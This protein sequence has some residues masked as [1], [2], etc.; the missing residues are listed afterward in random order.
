MRTQRIH[1]ARASLILVALI[2]IAI[3][4]MARFQLTEAMRP[5]NDIHSIVTTRA[6][7]LM[8]NREVA[9]TASSTVPSKTNTS[10]STPG[11]AAFIVSVIAAFGVG[12]IVSALITARTTSKH[13]NT[14][15]ANQL[16]DLR[17]QRRKECREKVD[18]QSTA[19]R[20][21][22][23]ELTKIRAASKPG[24]ADAL[25]GPVQDVIITH[26]TFRQSAHNAEI[27]LGT[28]DQLSGPADEV[29]R[30]VTAAVQSVLTDTT[31]EELQRLYSDVDQALTRFNTSLS[32]LVQ[33]RGGSE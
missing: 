17:L 10:S 32:Q 20:T 7:H 33:Q 22:V 14:A 23:L 1:A 6:T 8:H 2:A 12:S 4:L 30:T 15:R 21:A 9:P 3:P 5:V 13:D 24:D 28:T 11:W 26:A 16:S 18:E 31:A 29:M 25:S 27:E 19:L